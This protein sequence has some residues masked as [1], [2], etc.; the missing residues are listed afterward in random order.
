M[1]ENNINNESSGHFHGSDPA[2]DVRKPIIKWNVLFNIILFLGLLILYILFFSSDKEKTKTKTT[3]SLQSID[4]ATKPNI[5]AFVDTDEIMDK[6]ELVIDMKKR[7]NEKM[8]RME[9]EIR[10]KQQAYEK[11][12]SYFQ[13]QVAKK[14][15]SERSAQMI[16]EKLMEEQQKLID[17][18]DNYSEELASEEYEM[19]VILVDSITNF[20]ERY[21]VN[22]DYDYVLGY[23]RGGGILLAKDTFDITDEV[24]S[25]MN[26][27]YSNMSK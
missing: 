21:N 6:Y 1:T 17:L 15:I 11:D 26:M 4:N 25:A 2:Q 24:L 22:H 5:I 14:S 13:E 7:L 18:Q 23:S 8:D 16:Y 20:L 27:E 19:N 3:S 9:S 12:A 10:T